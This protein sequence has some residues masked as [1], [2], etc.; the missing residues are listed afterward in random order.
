MPVVPTYEDRGIRLDPGLTFRDSTHATGEMFGSQVGD[1]LG[2]LGKGLTDV[3][4]AVAEVKE[5]DDTNSA[6]DNNNGFMGGARELSYGK[7]GY[8]ASTG[9]AAVEGLDGYRKGLLQLAQDGA[10]GLSPLA[11]RKYWDSANVTINSLMDEAAKHA[12]QE[13]KTWAVESSK[14]RVDSFRENAAANWDKPNADKLDMIAAFTEYQQLGNLLG[15]NADELARQSAAL[16]SDIHEDGIRR[17]AEADPIGAA[18]DMVAHK[19]FLLPEAQDR[20][21]ATVGKAADDERTLRS[22]MAFAGGSR[23]PGGTPLISDASD[24]AP[25]AGPTR[26]KGFLL[27]HTA[28]ANAP[29]VLNLDTSFTTNLAAMIEDAPAKVRDSLGIAFRKGADTMHGDGRAV[30]LTYHGGSIDQAPAD[31]QDWLRRSAGSYDLSLPIGGGPEGSVVASTDGVAARAL[32]PSAEAIDKHLETVTDP[33]RQEIARQAIVTTLDQQS[34]QEQQQQQAA[35]DELWRQVDAGA[36]PDTLPYT[37]RQAAGSSAMTVARSYVS[38]ALAGP[39]VSDDVLLRDM[40]LFAAVRPED[41]SRLDLNDYR[42]RL[43]KSDLKALA[44]T[45]TAIGRDSR[46]ARDQGAE[47][48]DAFDMARTRLVN[49]GALTPG[50]ESAG[51]RQLLARVQNAVYTG[52]A[53]FRAANPKGRPTPSDIY[54]TVDPFLMSYYLPQPAPR[55][56]PTV[57]LS[58]ISPDLRTSITRQLAMEL[59]RKPTDGEVAREYAAFRSAT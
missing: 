22:A 33:R 38:K 8:M 16:I 45:Q 10:K 34:R 31:V 58:D 24:G 55:S 2:T 49:A 59:G 1:A 9:R 6:K 51:Q 40:R 42:D 20:L 48:K 14:A 54:K 12:M 35:K 27:D 30:D 15:W 28:S 11:S 21:K 19:D 41:F 29:A 53:D 18:D 4:K 56:K 26:Q 43:E 36:A 17:K 39:I 32:R 50:E 44:E 46:K 52:L 25:A 3:G 37:V 13:R 47:L 23:T 57:K 7:D 5:L